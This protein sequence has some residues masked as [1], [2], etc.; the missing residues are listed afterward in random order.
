MNVCTL[1]KQNQT[2][3][4]YDIHLEQAALYTVTIEI[5]SVHHEI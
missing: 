5:Y 4:M 1:T 3:E 2:N